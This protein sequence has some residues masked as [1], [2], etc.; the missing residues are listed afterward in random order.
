MKRTRMLL[1]LIVIPVL[2]SAC[3]KNLP[4]KNAGKIEST[5]TREE[6]LADQMAAAQATGTAPVVSGETTSEEIEIRSGTTPIPAGVT[7]DNPWDYCQAVGTISTPGSEYTGAQTHPDVTS[8][9]LQ[10]MGIDNAEAGSFSVIWRCMNGQVWGCDSSS[11]PNCP[12]PVDF[13][14]EPSDVMKQECAKPEMENIVLPAAVTGR[15]TAYE[16]VCRNGVPEISGQAVSADEY[17]F[18]ASIWF[19]VMRQ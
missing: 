16:W 4:D 1:W 11:Y 3:L 10:A 17:G 12:N 7:Y 13:S 5:Q 15:E 14:S 9:V 8:S 2:L 6:I 18:N 19:P